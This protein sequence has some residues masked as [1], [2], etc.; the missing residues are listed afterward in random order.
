MKIKMKC[1][2]LIHTS[3]VLQKG[4]QIDGYRYMHPDSAG[5]HACHCYWTMSHDSFDDSQR[6]SARADRVRLRY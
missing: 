4:P 2:Q 1:E 3:A 5:R 6:S